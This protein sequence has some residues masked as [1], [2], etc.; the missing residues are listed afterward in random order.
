MKLSVVVPAFNEANQIKKTVFR[1][2]SYLSKQP[3]AHEIIVV[4]DGSK[5]ETYAVLQKL[6]K[7]YPALQIIHTT[8]N[9]GKG[10]SVK[11]GVL[12]AK[13]DFIFFTDADL[14]TPPTEIIKFVR[15]FE[16]QKNDVL[17]GSR[18]VP[19]ARIRVAQSC[20]RRLMGRIF[21]LCVKILTPLRFQDTQCGFK[22][23]KREAA[24]SI[25]SKVTED[26][27]NFDVE[28]LLIARELNLKVGE[29]PIT[30]LNHNQS[31]INAI[32]DSLSMFEGLFRLRKQ[33]KN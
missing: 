19:G 15:I 31:K 17:I 29:I 5:D 30:W 16:S 11:S 8:A 6:T 21:N 25:F 26:G 3:Y 12:T 10:H 27:F 20:Q 18:H 24:V 33:F 1:L 23:F 13:G 28:S 9:H 2:A 7:K 4:D 22:G 14:S 32:K